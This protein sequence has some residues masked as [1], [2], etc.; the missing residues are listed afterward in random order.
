MALIVVVAVSLGIGSRGPSGPV[1]LDQHVTHLASE[2]RC[3]SCPDLSAAESDAST[4]R[5]VRADI[6]D[7]ILAGHTDAVIKASLVAKYGS[8]IL[9]S[10]TAKGVGSLVWVLPLAAMV[11]ALAG[12]AGVFW[13]RRGNPRADQG[14]T[15]ADRRLVES[16][17][18]EAR[19]AEA[20]TAE[21]RTAEARTAEARTAS[22]Q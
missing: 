4:A 22:T 16:Q 8:G 17:V 10:P 15:T 3:P 1:T 20:R 7:Q 11:L 19:T 9:L 6:R 12:L 13:R 2:F 21:A 14:P 18:A 5:A